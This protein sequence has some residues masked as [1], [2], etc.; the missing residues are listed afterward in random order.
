MHKNDEGCQPKMNHL[1]IV[2][3]RSKVLF[4]TYNKGR[5]SRCRSDV[6]CAW[7][8]GDEHLNKHIQPDAHNSRKILKTGCTTGEKSREY[9]GPNALE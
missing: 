5:L 7:S 9:K 1:N 2:L 6:F 8:W 4:W 3:K